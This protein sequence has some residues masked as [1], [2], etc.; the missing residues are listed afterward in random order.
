MPQ[1]AWWSPDR[2]VRQ[3]SSL[4]ALWLS[5]FLCVKT[6]TPIPHEPIP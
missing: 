6:Q 1:L 3:E 4:C 5:I 2:V